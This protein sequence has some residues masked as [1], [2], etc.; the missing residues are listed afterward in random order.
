[1]SMW[2][3]ENRE[4]KICRLDVDGLTIKIRRI[5]KSYG[6][7]LFCPELRIV[8]HYIDTDSLEKAKKEGVRVVTTEIE[9]LDKIKYLIA[10]YKTNYESLWH[11]L[12]DLIGSKKV[13]SPV[14]ILEAMKDM[15]NKK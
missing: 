9:R 11:Q 5:E 15:E 10:P 14:K 12:K 8:N 6:W 7:F 4:P 1:M 3:D 13:L 2:I